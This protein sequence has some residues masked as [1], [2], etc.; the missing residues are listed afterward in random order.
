MLEFNDKKVSTLIENI[1]TI[2]SNGI[3]KSTFSF[4]YPVASEISINYTNTY[5]TSDTVIVNTG[6]QTVETIMEPGNEDIVSV[7][8]SPKA[9]DT[10]IYTL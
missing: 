8:I 3:A 4:E 6:L 10:Y 1:L 2:T 7:T 9:D 5:G